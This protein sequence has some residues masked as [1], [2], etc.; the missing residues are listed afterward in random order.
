MFCSHQDFSPDTMSLARNA[1]ARLH[2]GHSP[3][4]AHRGPGVPHSALATSSPTASLNISGRESPEGASE[5]TSLLPKGKGKGLDSSFSTSPELP[6]PSFPKGFSFIDD[7]DIN[8]D[9]CPTCLEGYTIENPQISTYC[10]HHFHLS[11]IYEWLERSHLCPVC[12]SKMRDSSGH[13]FLEL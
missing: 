10:K 3:P 5:S 1:P 11:C 4:S 7:S 13:K 9:V 6:K 12:S 8:M 2:G